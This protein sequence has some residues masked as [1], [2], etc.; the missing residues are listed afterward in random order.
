MFYFRVKKSQLKANLRQA[1][2]LVF[3]CISF[4]IYGSV[5]LYFYLHSS[6]DPLWTRT[7][8]QTHAPTVLAGIFFVYGVYALWMR[9]RVL[10]KIFGAMISLESAVVLVWRLFLQDAPIAWVRLSGAI[11]GFSC[12]LIMLVLFL[13]SRHGSSVWE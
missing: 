10:G 11:E 7:P 12:F 3:F 1:S 6:L 5:S 13:V 2:M 9:R 4:F 8:A